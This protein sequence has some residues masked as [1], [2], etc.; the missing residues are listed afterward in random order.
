MVIRAG[1]LVS[2]C[3]SLL[4]DGEEED[5]VVME[6][7]LALGEEDAEEAEGAE[8]D[9]ETVLDVPWE[10]GDPTGGRSGESLGVTVIVAEEEEEVEQEAGI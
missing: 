7:C 4:E 9:E 2:P 8:E 6:L 3:L 10:R 5:G 1:G